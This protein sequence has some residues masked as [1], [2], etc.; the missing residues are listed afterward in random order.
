MRRVSVFAATSILLFL[1]ACAAEGPSAY[2]TFNLAVDSACKATA[3][4][5]S[6]T[7]FIPVG[8]FDISTGGIPKGMTKHTTECDTSYYMNLMVNSN[9]RPNAKAATGRAE[10]NI[11]QIHSAEVHLMTLKRE[12]IA[13]DRNKAN[14]LP[15]PFLVTTANTLQPASGTTPSIGVVSIEAI[16]R[17]YAHQLDKFASSQILAEVQVF[18]TTLGD[19][20]VDFKSFVY[21]IQLC[22]GC[23]TRCL[24]KDIISNNLDVDTVYGNDCQDDAGQD[25]RVC[26]DTKC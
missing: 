17:D 4:T 9:L 21:P 16:P 19:V 20:D 10:P 15:N 1:S 18:G 2:V 26:I 5:G 13:F 12:T 6:G 23:L 22:D 24:N 7:Q 3:S 14:V 11:L 25:G 8:Q